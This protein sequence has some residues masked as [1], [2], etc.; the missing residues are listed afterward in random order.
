MRTIQRSLPMLT[1]ALLVLA[2][3]EGAPTEPMDS[4]PRFT[5]VERTV[6]EA[7]Y[8]LDGSY[9]TFGCSADGEPLPPGEGELIALRGQVYERIVWLRDGS[10]EIHFT[11][12]TM[13]VEVGGTGVDSGE[14]FRVSYHDQYNASQR[15]EG[16]S[17]SYHHQFKMVGEESGRTAWIAWSGNYRIGQ[18]GEIVVDRQLER[19]V[20]R[21]R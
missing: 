12:H 1:A 6:D 20:C 17:G 8:D 14:E 2:G 3:C 11:L 18:D 10:G 16:N 4:A 9:T 21:V 15:L 7:L 5:A 19:T 13:P